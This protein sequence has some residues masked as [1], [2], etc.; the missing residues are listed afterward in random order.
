MKDWRF[1]SVAA[2][3]IIVIAFMVAKSVLPFLIGAIGG[4]IAIKMLS[5][6]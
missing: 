3:T 1:L 6:D 2:I 5:S 4:A